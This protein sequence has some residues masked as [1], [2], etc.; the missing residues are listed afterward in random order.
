MLLLCPSPRRLQLVL[1]SVCNPLAFPGLGLGVW[2]VP[3]ILDWSN[4]Q[5][6]QLQNIVTYLID[7]PTLLM[8]S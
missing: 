3:R 5:N 1:V 4:F 8:F 2:G 7:L 6:P